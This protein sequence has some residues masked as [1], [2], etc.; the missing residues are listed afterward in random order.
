MWT[1]L[2]AYVVN[3]CWQLFSL[4]K[5]K[6]RSQTLAVLVG[7]ACLLSLTALLLSVWTQVSW[8]Y[9]SSSGQVQLVPKE[10][11]VNING[12]E[13]IPVKLIS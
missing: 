10:R 12:I 2:K 6:Q 8:R 11:V 7:V 5:W 1:D 9:W 13:Y 3:H 4:D